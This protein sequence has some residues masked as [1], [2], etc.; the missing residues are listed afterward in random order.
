MAWLRDPIRYAVVGRLFLENWGWINLALIALGALYAFWRNWR[1]GVLLLLTWFGFT[2][3]ALN[4]YVPDLAVFLIAAQ[5][6][7]AL[8]WAAGAAGMLALV[9][10]LAARPA[11]RSRPRRPTLC[12]AAV[13]AARAGHGRIKLAAVDRSADD[14]LTTWGEAV[15]DLPLAQGAAI[16]ADSEK[17]APL[18][19]LQQAEGVRP[20]LDIMVLPDEAAYRAE[21][22][23]RLTAGQPVYLARFLPGLEGVYHLR[24]VGP[25]L[26]VS[27]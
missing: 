19:Y 4:Y 9:D 6:V 23:A 21:L 11:K 13:G 20:D 16:L 15:L 17:I 1:V 8:W 25:L 27:T 2:F 7:M 5:V 24:S 12:A 14:G 22:D 26:E 10:V 18:Y 3:Y